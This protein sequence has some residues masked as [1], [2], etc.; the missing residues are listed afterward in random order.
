MRFIKHNRGDKIGDNGIIYLEEAGYSNNNL[1]LIKAQCKCGN[2]FIGYRAYISKNERK[3]CGCQ[4]YI[5]RKKQY[6][7]GQL[8]GSND[9]SYVKDVQSEKDYRTIFAK[10]FCGNTFISILSNILTDKTSSCGCW[11]HNLTSH[12]LYNRWHGIKDRCYNPNRVNYHKY[13]AKGVVIHNE[14]K[15]NFQAFYDYMITLPK[16]DR[17]LI[18][19]LTID[20]YPDKKGN[21]ESGNL[22]WATIKEQNNNRRNNI[23]I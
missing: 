14:W 1:R 13:G 11:K 17:V 22:R 5:S 15:N 21:Y 3:S 9:I 6:T 2:I 23:N 8:I 16:Y 20:R 18:D 12:W 7:E 19:H 10:C 4:T